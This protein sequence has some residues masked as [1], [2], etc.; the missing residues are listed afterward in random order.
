MKVKKGYRTEAARTRGGESHP[1]ANR[2]GAQDET[3]QGK[4]A[5]AAS[6]ILANIA[7]GSLNELRGVGAR[8]HFLEKGEIH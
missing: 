1:F 3:G 5:K 6:Q 4:T 2:T 7:A 8:V